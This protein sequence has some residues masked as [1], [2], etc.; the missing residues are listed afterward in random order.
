M[1]W[2]ERKMNVEIKNFGDV[3]ISRPA[4]KEA[5]LLAESYVFNKLN[6]TESIDLDFSNVKV[7]TPSWVDEFIKGVKKTYSNRINYLHTENASVQASLR[8]VLQ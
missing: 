4:G 1:S 5:F 3:L 8:T 2:G 7:L 6:A